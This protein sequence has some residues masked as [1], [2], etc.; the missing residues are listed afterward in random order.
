M[1]G[2]QTC[3]L[4]ISAPSGSGTIGDP[5][6]IDEVGD[7]ESIMANPCYWSGYIVLQSDLDMAGATVSPIGNGSFKFRGNFNGNGHIIRNLTIYQPGGSEFVG[8]FG[9]VHFDAT[10]SNLGVEN[11]SITGN[12]YVVVFCGLNNYGSILNCHTTGIVTGVYSVGGFCGA[13]SGSINNSYSIVNVSGTQMIGGFV[14]NNSSGRISNCYSSGNAEGD[15]DVGG[16]SGYNHYI[17][18]NCYSTGDPNGNQNIGGFC[19]QNEAGDIKHCYSMGIP[20]G[21][22]YVGGFTGYN[23]GGGNIECNFWLFKNKFLFDI[24]NLGDVND[25]QIKKIHASFLK[26]EENFLCFDFTDIWYMSEI[27]PNLLNVGGSQFVLIPTL[28]EWAVVIFISL[29]SLLGSWFIWK[30]Q[31]N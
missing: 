23:S 8:L 24:G 18:N 25:A 10:I 5:W 19:G 14:G 15:R 28:T 7:L 27:K 3:A 1:T 22:T 6:V 31:S 29:F 12:K 17:I 26:D 9:L 2:V 13:N 11:A 20:S 21:T 16:F 4:P 30:R